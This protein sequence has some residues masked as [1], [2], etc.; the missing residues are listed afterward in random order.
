M[1]DKRVFLEFDRVLI[2]NN[3]YSPGEIFKLLNEYQISK[4]KDIEKANNDK[5]R[6]ALHRTN[7]YSWPEALR[8]L[9]SNKTKKNFI[10]KV[11]NCLCISVGDYDSINVSGLAQESYDELLKYKDEILLNEKWYLRVIPE[12][13][14]LLDKFKELK[15]A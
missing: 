5:H 14:W 6:V 3:V 4:L 10:F 2:E 15:D 7:D 1:T 9:Q 8:K 12:S 13:K 11:V